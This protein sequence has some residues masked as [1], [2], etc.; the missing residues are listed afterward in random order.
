MENE[1]DPKTLLQNNQRFVSNKNFIS[2]L[3][4]FV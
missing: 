2:V 1:P 3:G 4:L